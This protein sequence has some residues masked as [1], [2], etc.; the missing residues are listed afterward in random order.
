MASKTDST[1]V[2][3]YEQQANE[4]ALINDTA[5]LERFAEM[6]VMIPS[7]PGE[8]TE[9]IMRQILAAENWDDLDAPWE[10]SDIEDIL[11]KTLRVTSVKRLPSTFAGGL[12]MFLVVGLIDPKTQT[13]Y[14]KTTGSISVVAQF[15][16]A[17]ALGITNML[18]EWKRADRPSKNGYFPQ[19]LRVLDATTPVQG[20]A[21]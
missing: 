3:V 18:I 10:T 13:T 9:N 19:H 1:D 2:D 21:Q 12:G 11:G 7:D 14:T 17:Y 5:L 16:R 6:A 4:V 8:G 15:A 20:N